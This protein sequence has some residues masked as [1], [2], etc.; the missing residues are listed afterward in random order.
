MTSPENPYDPP[1]VADVVSNTSFSVMRCVLWA[2]ATATTVLVL[3]SVLELNQSKFAVF[4]SHRWAVAA[5]AGVFGGFASYKAAP[6][7]RGE[8]HRI[9]DICMAILI[10]SAL[11][12]LLLLPAIEQVFEQKRGAFDSV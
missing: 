2:S 3:A 7:P 12:L 11:W 8:K 5:F 10:L 6:T 1:R 9:S 4:L